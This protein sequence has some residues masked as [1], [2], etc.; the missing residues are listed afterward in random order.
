MEQSHAIILFDG[1]CNLCNRSVQF[2]L[3]RDKKA[4]FQFAALQSEAGQA[5][6]KDLGKDAEQFNSVVL[7]E[8]GKVYEKSTAALRIA[9]HLGGAWPL[10]YGFYIV[11]AFIR[12]GVYS[13]IARNRYRWFGQKEHCMMPQPEWKERFL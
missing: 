9:R 4:Y 2:I 11:P 3:K 10:L 5:F 1:V 13:W 12:D 6:L 7:I 8:K